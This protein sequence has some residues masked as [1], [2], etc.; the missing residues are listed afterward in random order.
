[1]EPPPDLDL[2]LDDHDHELEG[3]RAHVTMKELR[4]KIK[5]RAD[6][7]FEKEAAADVRAYLKSAVKGAVTVLYERKNGDPQG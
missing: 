7:Q 1:M 5:H 2:Y 3:A 4:E 6:L